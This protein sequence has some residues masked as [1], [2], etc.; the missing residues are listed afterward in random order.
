[1]RAKVETRNPR[2]E[3]PQ[4]RGGQVQLDRRTRS[5]DPPI[6][7]PGDLRLSGF[8]LLSAF[9][10]RASDFTRLLLALA[11]AL[12]L[13]GCSFLKPARSVARHFVLTPLPAV[14]P[15]TAASGSRGVGVGPVKLPAYLFETS[16]AV[17][18][19]T[20]EIEYFPVALWGERLDSGVQRVLAANLSTLLST[21]RIRLSAWRSDEVSAGV[22][23]VIEQF[24]VDGSGRGV[25]AGSWRIVSSDGEKTLQAGRSRFAR[26]GPRPDADLAGTVATLS[27]LLADLS[28]Q[29]AQAILETKSS[30]R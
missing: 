27:E 7:P 10:L 13:T 28:R 20:N 12:G 29:L 8:G 1:M 22:Y 17:R 3:V 21:D 11:A 23:V 19:G 16:L 14:E 30:V 9:G 5:D 26:Q 24:E 25:I 2:P 18:K 4:P 15:A 6:R